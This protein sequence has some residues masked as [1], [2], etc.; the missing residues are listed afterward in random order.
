MIFP[1]AIY[2][3]ADGFSF[4]AQVATQGPSAPPADDE[5]KRDLPRTAAGSAGAVGA[6]AADRHLH[7]SH[8]RTDKVFPSIK[9]TP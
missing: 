3:K 7:T 5:P 6:M 1:A 8:W 2:D 9:A 4:G